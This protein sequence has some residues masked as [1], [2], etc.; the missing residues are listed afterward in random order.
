MIR[1]RRVW[2][3]V[4]IKSFAG[5]KKRLSEALD[6][7]TRRALV[8]AMAEDVIGELK[9]VPGLTGIL[10]AT[11]SDEVREFAHKQTVECWKDPIETDLS[12][13]VD[14]AARY[15]RSDF[16]ADTLMILPCD[17]PLVESET[18]TQALAQHKDLTLASDNEGEGTNLL[19]ASPP[20]LIDFC[21]D[22]HGF[23]VHRERGLALGAQV[24]VIEDDRIQLDVDTPRDLERLTTMGEGI[25]GRRT[26]NLV[27]RNQ[28]RFR[29]TSKSVEEV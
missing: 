26:L 4:P 5:A 8:R 21:Y 19:I 2:A 16:A 13:A 17:V 29:V 22:G 25:E 10:I 11:R 18:L 14:G 12:T 27:R 15:L 7:G 1:S 23:G 3:L 28:A 6:L 24:Q 20:H 9:K